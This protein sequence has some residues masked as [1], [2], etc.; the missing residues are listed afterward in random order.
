[1]ASKVLSAKRK[2]ATITYE[3]ADGTNIELVVV[4]ISTKESKDISEFSKISTNTGNDLFEKIARIHLQRNDAK[5]VNKIM[6]EQTEGDGNVIDF[7]G[8]LS[9]VIEE[10][11]KE[12]GNG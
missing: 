7:A 11:K 12:K 9:S 6:K 8:A 2:E 4:G 3:Q 10:A 5:V 1:M